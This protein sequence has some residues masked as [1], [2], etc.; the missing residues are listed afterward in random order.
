MKFFELRLL[1]KKQLRNGLIMYNYTVYVKRL[2]DK[3]K[4]QEHTEIVDSTISNT[5]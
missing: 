1:N 3:F 5:K 2:N 4:K